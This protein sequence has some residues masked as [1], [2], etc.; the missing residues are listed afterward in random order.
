MDT[1]I[2]KISEIES[3]ATAI[4][5][6]ANKRKA[7]FAKEMEERTAIF[8]QQLEEETKKRIDEL[9][10]KKEV[11]MKQRLN[12]QR[13]ISRKVLEAMEKRYRDHHTQY[14]EELF[15]KMTKE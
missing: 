12:E 8:D 4:M 1:V 5:E 9:R 11:E 2:E 10:A 3:S 13:S 15:E 14:V 6:E 7:A